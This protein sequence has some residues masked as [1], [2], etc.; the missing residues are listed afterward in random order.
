LKRRCADDGT[1]GVPEDAVIAIAK[2]HKVALELWNCRD[3]ERRER[4]EQI[5]ERDGMTVVDELEAAIDEM[6]LSG[7]DLEGAAIGIAALDCT[8]PDHESDEYNEAVEHV[9]TQT[10]LLQRLQSE[11]YS[12]FPRELELKVDEMLD[13][14]NDGAERLEAGFPLSA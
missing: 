7:N 6:L 9:L 10:C 2:R 8:Y 13:I 3:G 5:L 14:I 12:D 4:L 1:R 11:F